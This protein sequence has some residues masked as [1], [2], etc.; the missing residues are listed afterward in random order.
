VLNKKEL[1][2]RVGISLGMFPARAS[3]AK[4]E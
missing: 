1:S 3:A 2:F 4:S